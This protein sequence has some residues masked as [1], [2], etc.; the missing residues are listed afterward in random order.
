MLVAN[1]DSNLI[2]VFARD[3]QTGELANEGKSFPA[4]TPMRIL[5]A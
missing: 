2:S 3:P 4:G 5:F 1:H